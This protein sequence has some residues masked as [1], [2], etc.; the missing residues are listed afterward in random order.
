MM[1]VGAE[2]TRRRR[3]R[4]W[5]DCIE[6]DHAGGNSKH[7]ALEAADQKHQLSLRVGKNVRTKKKAATC[8][9]FD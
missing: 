2:G 3:P 6:G 9:L 4:R 7:S 5:L 8:F 1:E